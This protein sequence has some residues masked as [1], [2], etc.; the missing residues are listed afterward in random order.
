MSECELVLHKAES[1]DRLKTGDLVAFYG[2]Q[3]RPSL[4]EQFSGNQPLVFGEKAN[5]ADLTRGR[6]A[7]L[8]DEGL[9]LAGAIAAEGGGRLVFGRG[10]A[11]DALLECGETRSPRSGGIFP[12][13]P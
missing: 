8:D 9:D 7:A 3:Y 4:R 10:E 12:A 13:L 1:F 2:Q 11:G 6:V 5:Q